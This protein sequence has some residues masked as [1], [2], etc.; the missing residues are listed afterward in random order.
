M[1]KDPKAADDQVEQVVQE[2]HIGNNSFVTTSEGPTV[3]NK[4]HQEDGLITQ[5]KNNEKHKSHS[6]PA[7]TSYKM[8]IW[9][10]DQ[11]AEQ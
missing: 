4:T 3:P 1:K 9:I 6:E 8:W 2:L 10:Y 11:M 5:L 7:A